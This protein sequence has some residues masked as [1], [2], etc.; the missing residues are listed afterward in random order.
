[1]NV[2]AS[3][4]QLYETASKQCGY[5]TAFQAVKAG[6]NNSN[7]E[8]HL[9]AGN[10]IRE[11]RG[12]Y[13]L[14]RYPIQEDAHYALWGIWSMNR[15]EQ[16]LGVY[17]HETALSLFELS[18]NQPVKL[19][20]TLPRGNRRHGDIPPVL[21]LHHAEIDEKDCEER[22]GYRV[23]KPYRTIIDVVRAGEL[24]PEF[25]CKTVKQALDKGYITQARYKI[26]VELPRIGRRLQAIMAG[27]K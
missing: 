11:W 15:S 3:E 5:F 10:W 9:R 22:N 2:L 12:I 24:S 18:D 23:T 20:M 26:M 16:I 17:S 6:F 21:L 19:H 7:H 27:F 8:Y 1:M 4:T 25:I 14:T 13:R